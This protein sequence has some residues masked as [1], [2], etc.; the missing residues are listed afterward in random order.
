MPKKMIGAKFQNYRPT[1]KSP[2]LLE[3]LLNEYM[4]SSDTT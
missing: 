3:R 2:G 4:K 1:V